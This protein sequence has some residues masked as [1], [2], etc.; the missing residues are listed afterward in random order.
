MAAVLVLASRATRETAAPAPVVD[1]ET[2][3]AEVAA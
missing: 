1:E 3:L 2:E